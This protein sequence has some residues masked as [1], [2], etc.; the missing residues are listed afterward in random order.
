MRIEKLNL[1]IVFGMLALGFLLN[2]FDSSMKKIVVWSSLRPIGR[3]L[4]QEKLDG[5]AKRYPNYQFIQL[6]YSPEEVRINFIISV[7]AGMEVVWGLYSA[8]AVIVSVPVA[9]LFIF[10][11]RWLISGFTLGSVKD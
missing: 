9:V 5:F 8:G 2:C 6:F 10:L 11:S 3:E 7:L 4:L 1:L